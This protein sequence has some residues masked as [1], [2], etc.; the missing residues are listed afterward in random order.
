MIFRSSYSSCIP[1]I[2]ESDIEGGGWRGLIREKCLFDITGPQEEEDGKTGVCDNR[3][4]AVTCVFCR[5]LHFTLM[6]SVRLQKDLFK[7]RWSLAEGF[8]QQNYCHVVTQRL[9]SFFL[10]RPVV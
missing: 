5:D 7:G 1:T 6:F 8:Y 2:Y 10:S 3:D 9:V 4:R